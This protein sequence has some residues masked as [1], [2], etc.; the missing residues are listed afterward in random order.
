MDRLTPDQ[1]SAV[2]RRVRRADTAPEMTVRRL[3]F[4]MGFRYRLHVKTLPGCPD[5]VFPARHAV[6]FVHGC[7]WH[8][9]N[10]RR[11]KAPSSNTEYWN[12]KRAKNIERDNRVVRELE[13]AGWSV[14][15]IWECEIKDSTRLQERIF[16]FLK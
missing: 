12:A 3:I 14:L 15:T 13:E 5:L 2:M 8:G 1:R 10:C 7:F 9:H 11:G 6:V 16:S 4:R